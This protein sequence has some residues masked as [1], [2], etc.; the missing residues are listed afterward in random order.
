[1]GWNMEKITILITAVG[2]QSMPGL[3][4]C[5]HKNGE[6]EV[7][8]VGADISD[9]PTI[10]QMV[11]TLYQVPKVYDPTYIDSLLDICKK[12]QVDI[13]FPFMDEELELVGKRLREFEELGVKVSIASS[14]AIWITNNKL[15]FYEFLKKN[16]VKVPVFYSIT[17]YGEYEDA[18]EKL[19]YPSE[20]VCIKTINGSGSRGIRILDENADLYRQFIEE[21][22][23]S[24]TVTKYIFDAII[25]GQ[26]HLEPMMA[27]EYLP[28]AECSV[29]VLA[30]NGKILYMVGRE[31]NNV[32]ASIPQD[33]VLKEIPEA[34]EICRKVCELLKIDGNADFDF[35]YDKEDKPVLMEVNPRLA[36]TL[37]VIAVG[38]VNLPYLRIKQILGEELP[39][40]D[41]KYGV[42][43]KRRYLDMFVDESG[44]TIKW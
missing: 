25:A 38:G 10:C 37:S 35:K 29:D 36:A 12:E 11:D 13:F 19:G 26:M 24:M 14:E 22:P 20:K 27:M 6:R 42:R 1:M 34:Y 7:R 31:S 4:D 23:N 2:T 30:E 28:G 41:V 39:K 3:A 15:R 21:K 44:K 8:I 33:S 18:C 32:L 17:S 16:N 43:F 5:F 40:L 9:D